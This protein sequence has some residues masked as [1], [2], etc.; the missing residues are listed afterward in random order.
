MKLI[1]V[2]MGRVAML[3]PVEEIR[4]TG[5]LNVSELVGLLVERYGFQF[6]PDLSRPWEE[7]QKSV[8]K[9][10]SGVF[11]VNNKQKN[12]LEF[13]IYNDGIV[14]NTSSTEDSEKFLEDMLGWA[15]DAF[16][17]REI[18]TKPTFYYS[19]QI[20]VE[21]DIDMNAL[22]SQFKHISDLYGKELKTLYNVQQL[23]ELSRLAINC[24]R[25]KLPITV[26]GTDFVME[27][28][29]NQPYEDKRFFCEAPLPTAQHL[30][31]LRDIEKAVGTN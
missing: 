2:E 9:F 30:Q 11:K 6:L 24:D 7:M 21:F 29:L 4:P 10:N 19:S 25:T 26:L 5:G 23:P 12:I 14:A 18:T 22:L 3:F 27:R 20:I 17:I 15:K 1:A 16:H 28:R 8:F 31:L 13:T